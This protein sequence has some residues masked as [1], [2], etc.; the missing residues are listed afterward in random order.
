MRVNILSGMIYIMIN[1]AARCL[2]EDIVD[3][4]GSIDIGMIFGTGFPAFRGGLLR[5]ADFIGINHVINSLERLSTK[6]NAER[7]KPCTYLIDLKDQRK[8]FYY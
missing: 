7:F 2:E 1:E 3:S 4:P 8:G 6:L 5:Y